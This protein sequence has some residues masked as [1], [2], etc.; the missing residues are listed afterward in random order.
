REDERAPG[1]A[2]PLRGA[3]GSGGRGPRDGGERR[4][5]GRGPSVPPGT[6]PGGAAAG[7]HGRRPP[8][9][10]RR[11]IPRSAAGRRADRAHRGLPPGRGGGAPRACRGPVSGRLLIVDDA[12][13]NLRILH[14]LLKAEGY[15]V[16]AATRGEVA[17]RAAFAP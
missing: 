12:P 1:R 2:L 11:R 3:P 13:E 17:L 8:P 15:T 16:L 14:G 7:P 10:G 6:P 5:A 4:A 9:R